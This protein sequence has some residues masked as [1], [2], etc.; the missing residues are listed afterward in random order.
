LDY[1]GEN[2]TLRDK[3]KHHPTLNIKFEYTAPGT[4]QQNGKVERMF[5]TLYG[6]ARSMLNSARFTTEIRRGLWSQCANHAVQLQNIIVMKHGELSAAEKFYGKNPSWI[7]NMR[8]FGEMAIIA[9]HK[10]RKI[11]NKLD[12]RGLVVIFIG[13]TEDHAPNVFKFFNMK[14]RSSLMSRD[15]IWLNKTFAEYYG[16]QRVVMQ[17]SET[18]MSGSDKDHDSYSDDDEDWGNFGLPDTE[19]SNVTQDPIDIGNLPD[20]AAQPPVVVIQPQVPVVQV[21]PQLPMVLP[22]PTIAENPR[23]NT[24]A[25]TPRYRRTNLEMLKSPSF[26]DSPNIRVTRSMTN[27][28]M[29]AENFCN[30]SSTPMSMFNRDYAMISSALKFDT[31]Q[32]YA[33]SNSDYSLVVAG[34]EDGSD[35]PK[36]YK[37]V[38]GHRNQDKWW[39]A[40]KEEFKAMETKGVWENRRN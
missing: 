7:K 27:V 5:A 8:T 29:T 28:M 13:Y 16:I 1:G 24:P 10:H 34:F 15:V 18:V 25:K 11:R 3:I 17:E 12:D 20:V 9:D 31:E 23:I 39:E 36:S 40:M 22:L 26:H 2:N 30:I 19:V 4:P 33:L 32:E 35:V 6:K 38:I 14:T 21:Q 37:D